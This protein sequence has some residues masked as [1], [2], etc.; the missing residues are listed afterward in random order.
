MTAR[1]VPFPQQIQSQKP[2]IKLSDQFPGIVSLFMFDKQLGKLYSSMGQKLLRGP[3]PLSEAER[4]LIGAFVSKMNECKFCCGSHT[5]CAMEVAKDP[6]RKDQ[7]ITPE[8]VDAVINGQ[9]V[10]V[11]PMKMR[12]LLLIANDIAALDREHLPVAIKFAKDEG[13]TD[14]EIHDTAAIAA[15]FCMCNRYVDGLGTVFKNQ[16]LADGGKSLA[17]YGYTMGIRRFFGEVL[18]QIMHR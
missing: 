18:P 16:D 4:E 7:R 11:L 14:Q 15:F 13:A 5:A 8:M 10:S 6:E 3:S 2:Y 17:K 1:V 12:Y 9:D